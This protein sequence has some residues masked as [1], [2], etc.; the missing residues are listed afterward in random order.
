MLLCNQEETVVI[1]HFLLKSELSINSQVTNVL[2]LNCQTCQP[3]LLARTVVENLE[4]SEVPGSLM[5]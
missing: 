4:A 2:I 5:N 1:I 3:V